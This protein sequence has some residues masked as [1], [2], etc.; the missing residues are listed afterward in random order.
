MEKH[1][2]LIGMID[3]YL[4]EQYAGWE[5]AVQAKMQ[6]G[7]LALR[8]DKQLMQLDEVTGFFRVNFS[9]ELVGLVQEVR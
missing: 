5:E 8:L 4:G 7:A 6:S 9:D 3:D 2:E 1:Q